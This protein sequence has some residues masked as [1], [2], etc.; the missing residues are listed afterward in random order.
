MSLHD[1]NPTIKFATFTLIMFGLALFYNPWTPLIIIVGTLMIQLMA[2][3]VS[4]KK[5]SLFTIP[6]LITALGTFWTTLVF[7]KDLGGETWVSILGQSISKQEFAVAVS[8][9]MRVLAFTVLSLLFMLTTD[10]KRF[11]MSLM[12][13]ARLSPTI[14]YSALVGFRFLPLMQQELHQLQYAHRLRGVPLNTR[15]ERIRHVP[16]LLLPL[17]A[18][19][20]RRA[21]R[22]AFSMEARGF[23]GGKRTVYERIDIKPT[24][25]VWSCVFF[26]LFGLSIW[27]GI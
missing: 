27:A 13:Q 22:I 2:T 16:K 12:Q 23:T 8:L 11:V 15:W 24:D 5:W 4:W 6:F 1:M 19:S 14:A 21:E 20:I 9:S 18:G 10:S 17:L 3:D 7:G 25:Y 26:L